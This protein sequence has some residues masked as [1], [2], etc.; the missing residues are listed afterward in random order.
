MD[1]KNENN[2]SIPIAIVFAGI[3]IAGAVFLTGDGS[4]TK[5]LAN[6]QNQEP[7]TEQ[8]NLDA[9]REI[10]S[11][12]RVRGDLN[13]P[14]V[15]VE[16]SDTEC[17]FCKQFHQTMKRIYDEYGSDGKVAWVYRHFPL[18]QIHLRAREEAHALEC[19][20]ELGGNDKF[21]QYT[22]R[23]Y[24]ITPANGPL[25][26]GELNRIAQFVGLDLTAFNACL[27]SG[28]YN[29]KITADLENA[30]ATGGRGTPWSIVITK[31]GMAPLS[32]AQPYEVV[33]MMIESLL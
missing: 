9:I 32:G 2:I 4:L 14:V 19:A 24:E 20:G 27:N 15:I 26:S 3:L 29:D 10:T 7:P 16:Y 23:L 12:D 18:E 21:W 5:R 1:S 17:Y 33:K 6:L 25:E 22:D 28:K 31:D 30:V 8:Y 11:E 13:A